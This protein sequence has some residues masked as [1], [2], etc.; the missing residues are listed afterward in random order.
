[1]PPAFAKGQ[2]GAGEATGVAYRGKGAADGPVSITP[3]ERWSALLAQ[4]AQ[5]DPNAVDHFL[6]MAS[7]AGK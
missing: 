5:N 1:M 2:P 3:D 7:K 4:I 6:R